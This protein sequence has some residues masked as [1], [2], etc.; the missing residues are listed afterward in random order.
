NAPAERPAEHAA[1]LAQFA[2]ANGIHDAIWIG[3]SLGCNA[4]AHVARMRPDLVRE[5]V[6]IGPLWSGRNPARRY[7]ALIA[8]AFREEL[9]LY[10]YVVREYW[11]CG[12]WRWFATLFRYREDLRGEPPSRARMIAGENDPLPDRQWIHDLIFVPGAHACHFS[13][14]EET[15]SAAMQ[16]EPLEGVPHDQHGQGDRERDDRNDPLTGA[17]RNSK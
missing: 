6:C 5:L 13:F 15:A 12:L 1:F 10:I 2:D 4:A 8:D 16:D 14:P 17:A 9:S 7:A 11:R 3:H